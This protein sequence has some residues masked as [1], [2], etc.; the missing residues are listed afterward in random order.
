GRVGPHTGKGRSRIERHRAA[1]DRHARFAMAQCVARSAMEHDSAESR[2]GG[3]AGNRTILDVGCK[4]HTVL[5][6]RIV[7]GEP[8]SI[9]S[10]V[11]IDG[12][13]VHVRYAALDIGAAA[14]RNAAAI[15]A[16]QI[17]ADSAVGHR[18]P[19]LAEDAAAPRVAA[20]G[21]GAAVDYTTVEKEDY[22]GP[23]RA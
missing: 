19:G 20:I 23:D 7:L 1:L 6:V 9:V 18:Q 15:A 21:D 14:D 13:V 16:C 3:I 22:V 12:R 5:G 17:S 8:G 10:S 2:D 11:G 4:L